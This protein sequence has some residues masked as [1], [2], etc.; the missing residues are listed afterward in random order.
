MVQSRNF[1]TKGTSKVGWLYIHPYFL[2]S[3]VEGVLGEWSPDRR[4]T[5][6]QQGSMPRAAEAAGIYGYDMRAEV[7]GQSMCAHGH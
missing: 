3:G 2:P 4:R 7:T 5:E 6:V 1:C